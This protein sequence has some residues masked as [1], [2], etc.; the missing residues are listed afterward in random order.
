MARL[1]WIVVLIGI[2]GAVATGI[3][4]IGAY[5][6]VGNLLG[7]P[8]PQMGTQ[9]TTLLW[10]GMPHYQG[11]PR[12]WRFAFGPTRIPGAEWVEIYVNPTGQII[13]TDPPDLEARLNAFHRSPY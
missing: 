7:A 3:S 6:A 2:A 4:W 12:A 11:H 1:F 9:T 13:V 8:P 10:K 5:T